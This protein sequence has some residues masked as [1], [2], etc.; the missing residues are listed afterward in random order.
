MTD[1]FSFMSKINKK[2]LHNL[3]IQQARQRTCHPGY[4]KARTHTLQIKILAP[5]YHQAAISA[6]TFNPGA[7][8]KIIRE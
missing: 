4:S 5:D 7:S 8:K 2:S 6:L 1:L 3:K